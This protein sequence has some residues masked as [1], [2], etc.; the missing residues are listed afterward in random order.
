[1]KKCFLHLGLHKTATS[2]FQ[3]CCYENRNYLKNFGITYYSFSC[4][5]A[6]KSNIINHSIPLYSLFSDKP[7]YY[8]I[9]LAWDI[10]NKIEEVNLHYQIQFD[11]LMQYENILLSGED[12]SLLN[13]S[14]LK[15]LI[16]N[17]VKNGFEVYPFA[18]F[19]KPYS[20]F[21]SQL[22]ETIK[23]GNYIPLIKFKFEKPSHNLNLTRHFNYLTQSKRIYNLIS[24]FGEKIKFYSFEDSIHHPNGPIGFIFDNFLK[25]DSS[26]IDYS[27]IKKNSGKSNLQVRVQNFL[28]KNEPKFLGTKINSQFFSIEKQLNDKQK[29][30]LSEKEYELVQEA[31]EKDSE[32]FEKCFGSSY[33]KE[34][35]EFTEQISITELVKMLV[36]Q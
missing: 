14:S 35:I 19:R 23:N 10:I 25:L 22:Q 18:L 8:H 30:L 21:C 32:Y 3:N 16:N 29:F 1:M 33:K 17:L 7:Q 2:S 34:I 28:N 4:R 26:K 31:I 24:F 20:Y 12:L 11:K 5:Q 9:N 36:I 13:I 15:K 6:N 27:F